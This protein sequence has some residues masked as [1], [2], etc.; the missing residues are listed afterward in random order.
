MIYQLNHP[1]HNPKY[2]PMSRYKYPNSIW[3]VADFDI[4]HKE[5]GQ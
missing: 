2:L 1:I 4:L 5:E 3:D